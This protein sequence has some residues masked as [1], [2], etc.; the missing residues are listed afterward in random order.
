MQA[1]DYTKMAPFGHAC[2]PV[3]PGDYEMIT[4]LPREEFP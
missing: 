1:V 3:E 2:L 4:G